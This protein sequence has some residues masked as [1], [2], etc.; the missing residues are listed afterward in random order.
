MRKTSSPCS[1]FTAE[2]CHRSLEDRKK[3][4]SLLFRIHGHVQGVFFRDYSVEMAKRC[5]LVGFVSNL[6]DGSVYGE[7]EGDVGQ[8]VLM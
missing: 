2:T 3:L 7:A 6:K 1:T 4:Y 8:L 5:G